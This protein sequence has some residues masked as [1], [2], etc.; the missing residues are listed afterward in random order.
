[1]SNPDPELPL[2]WLPF[3]VDELGERPGNLCY[4]HVAP[5]VGGDLPGSVGEVEFY[6]PPYQF[7]AKNSGVLEKMS[8]LRVVQTMSAGVDHLVRYV[9]D[10]V[11][12]CRGAGVH[13]ASAAELTLALILSSLRGIPDFVRAQDRAEWGPRWTTSLADRTVLIVG[14]GS[15][16]AAIERRLDG[17][18]TT[19]R[20]V[21][22]RAR[23][24]VAAFTDLP[25]LLPEADVVV[26][27][28]PMTEETRGMAD[29][30][31]LDSM[32]EGA[33]LVNMARGPVVETDALVAE[34]A[35]GRIH[36]TLD[37]SDPEPLPPDHPL[38]QSPNLLISPH[39]GGASSAM[40]PRARA[41]VREQLWRY[42]AG[43]P[44][45]HVVT[46]SY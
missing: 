34:L 23:A 25:A 11:T 15:V 40:W 36:A 31:F 26:L 28:V 9:P 24:G 18:E 32:K 8:S 16:G 4:E 19:V 6:V 43:E 35:R 14:Y 44:L 21:A 20:R 46:G 17:F 5:E 7:S 38:W 42:A 12:L 1:V 45:Q 10:G 30:T 13:D 27:I 2:V 37:V 29:A 33:L 3:A 39:V 22:R 41:M